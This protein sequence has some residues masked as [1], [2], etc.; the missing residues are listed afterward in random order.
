MSVSF[1][2][3]VPQGWKMDLVEIADPEEQYEA[4]TAVARVADAGPWDSIWLYDHFH[5]WPEPSMNTTFE[6]W[7]ATS[8]LARDTSRVNIGQMVG[9]NGYRQP[10]LYA[11]IASTVDVASKGRLYAGLGAGWYEDEWKA[12][13]YRWE[14][15]PTRMA[16]FREAVE[17]ITKMWTED[18]PVYQGKHYSIDGP[19]NQPRRKPSFWLGGGGEKVTLKLVAQYADGCNVGGGDPALV[20][21]KLGVLRAHCDRLGRDYDRIRKSTTIELDL[22]QSTKDT[23]AHVERLADAGADYVLFYIPRVAYDHSHLLRLAEE[24]VPQFS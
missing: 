21:H 18:R 13:G 3:F 19:I 10:S 4:M 23:I 16:E 9:C 20:K 2:V 8:T 6:C 22:N 14:D 5:T 7:T 1:G 12:Y 24:V 17:V 11:K 15:V